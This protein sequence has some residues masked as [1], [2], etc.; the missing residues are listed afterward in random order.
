MI[1]TQTLPADA[2]LRQIAFVLIELWLSQ[3]NIDL[4]W[5]WTRPTQ[6]NMLP[7]PPV[8]F[9]K[10]EINEYIDQLCNVGF[11][12]CIS[13]YT[14]YEWDR[15][16]LYCIAYA[17]ESCNSVTINCEEI[18]DEIRSDISDV[19]CDYYPRYRSYPDDYEL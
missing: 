2:I 6:S 7:E 1:Q 8:V 18:R 13:A 19:L 3:Q 14:P 16:F 17:L 9:C 15:K 5:S 10:A 11:K 12:P 4:G